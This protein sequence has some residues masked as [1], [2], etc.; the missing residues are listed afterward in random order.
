MGIEDDITSPCGEYQTELMDRRSQSL[1]A[2]CDRKTL[3][4]W[5]SPR[6][7]NVPDPSHAVGEPRRAPMVQGG[8]A[9]INGRALGMGP[10]DLEPF[11]PREGEARHEAKPLPQ[12][13][14]PMGEHVGEN[15]TKAPKLHAEGELGA[16]STG[17]WSTISGIARTGLSHWEIALA[18]MGWHMLRLPLMIHVWSARIM[19][20]ACAWLWAH[21]HDP[22]LGRGMLWGLAVGSGLIAA[23]EALKL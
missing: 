12:T 1:G 22:S 10:D 9:T 15:P 3:I 5:D 23:L 4:R 14:N 2:F 17:A 13:P 18:A 19:I 6:R 7:V 11:S 8:C 21:R 20:R 16:R